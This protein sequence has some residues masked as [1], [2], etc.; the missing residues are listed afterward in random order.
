MAVVVGDHDR[1]SDDDTT[2]IVYKVEEK[3]QHSEYS[4][5]NYNNDIALVKIDRRILFNDSRRPVCLPEKG[6]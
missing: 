2:P 4:I 5:Q 3:I 6:K 1:T